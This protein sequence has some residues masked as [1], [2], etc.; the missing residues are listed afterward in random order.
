MNNSYIKPALKALSHV[1]IKKNYKVIRKVRRFAR[2]PKIKLYQ[3]WDYGIKCKNRRIPVR[4][5]SPSAKYISA[6]TINDYPVIM[7]FHGGGWVTG[8]LDTY[9]KTCLTIA[10]QTGHIVIAVQYRLAPE[11]PFPAG[12]CDCYEAVKFISLICKKK[13]PDKK[14]TLMG[15]SAGGN[16]AA[17][18]CL[19]IR[20]HYGNVEDIIDRQILIYPAVYNNHTETSPF[21]SVKDFGMDYILTAQ[22]ICDYM[23]MYCPQGKSPLRTRNSPYLAPLLAEDLSGL[24]ATLI[25]TAEF[26]PLRDE[27]EE[28]GRRL[29]EA[30]NAVVVHRIKD[31]L[32]GYFVLSILFDM[33]KETYDIINNFIKG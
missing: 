4:F 18:L 1:D 19:Y 12:L 30:G 26:D 16:L 29:S 5:F 2:K 13:D 25:I 6:E 3:T 14:I 20:D 8:D 17:S 21:N 11:H 9:E 10:R 31:A 22:H 7:F 32:H 23:D 33:V 27:A 24:P 15:D 28:Y